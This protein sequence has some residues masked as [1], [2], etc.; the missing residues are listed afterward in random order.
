MSSST[1]GSAGAN[2]LS[3]AVVA[4]G[5]ASSPSTTGP[6]GATW[7]VPCQSGAGRNRNRGVNG[8]GED[9][10][11]IVGII[12]SYYASVANSAVRIY[13]TISVVQKCFG[14]PGC[15]DPPKQ[16]KRGE[17]DTRII[18]YLARFA[19]INCFGGTESAKGAKNDHYLPSG[20]G[21]TVARLAG[22]TGLPTG[23]VCQRWLHPLHRRRRPD[24]RRR[25]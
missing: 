21:L 2:T 6:A 14:G 15:P 4:T 24:A 20:A 25:K 22:R 1:A 8:T 17:G 7:A 9:P 11:V 5:G 3:G 19:S 18:A 12:A 16:E 13:C 10:G 23:R